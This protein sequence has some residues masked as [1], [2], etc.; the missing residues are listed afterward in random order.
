MSREIKFRAWDGE[1]MVPQQAL[2]W[3]GD[4]FYTGLWNNEETHIEGEDQVR[5]ELMQY[6]GLKDR[7]GA[8]IYDGDILKGY[9]SDGDAEFVTKVR[10]IPSCFIVDVVGQD[11]DLCD[12]GTAIHELCHE[13][14]V[15]G[16]IHEN[17]DLLK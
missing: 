15:I 3:D 2:Y 5:V 4:S 1:K 10:W 17:P 9:W 16:N 7:N 13:Y 6:A 12:L 14:E 11:F 8:E